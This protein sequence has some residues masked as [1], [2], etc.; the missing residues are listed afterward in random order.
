[1]QSIWE[2][3][4]WQ[5]AVTSGY[6]E[7]GWT[8][9]TVNGIEVTH[10]VERGEERTSSAERTISL[11]MRCPTPDAPVD[12][13]R[14]ALLVHDTPGLSRARHHRSARHTARIRARP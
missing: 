12:R 11:L 8:M 9:R 7:P 6:A 13:C 5:E 14:L 3:A 1:M 10:Y 2:P 4:A